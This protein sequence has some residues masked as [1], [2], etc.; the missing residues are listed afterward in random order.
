[1]L[2]QVR[3]LTP[4]ARKGCGWPNTAF[5]PTGAY[6]EGN[7]LLDLYIHPL[8]IVT[9]LFG[10]GEIVSVVKINKDSYILMLRHQHIVGTV[11]LSTCL[12]WMDASESL[13]IRTH[14]GTYELFPDFVA[15]FGL[16]F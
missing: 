3:E 14:S 4:K 2:S 11:E 6:P 12:S 8:D 15:V 1:M 5:S 13:T 10:K 16:I 7:V 9:W